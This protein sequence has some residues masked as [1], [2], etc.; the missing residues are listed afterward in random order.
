MNFQ[1][2]VTDLAPVSKPSEPTVT[3]QSAP[4]AAVPVVAPT[5]GPIDKFVD[6]ARNGAGTALMTIGGASATGFINGSGILA[7]GAYAAISGNVAT[8]GL[9]AAAF[10]VNYATKLVISKPLAAI[11]AAVNGER[12]RDVFAKL[13][14]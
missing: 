5:K 9:V 7:A 8:A 11:G 13:W 10:A 2:G 3:T 4:A 6:G 1:L 12:M 14:P